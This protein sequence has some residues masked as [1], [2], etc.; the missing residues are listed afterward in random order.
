MWPSYLK[1]AFDATDGKKVTYNYREYTQEGA[2]VFLEKVAA[3]ECRE[4]YAAEDADG[5]EEALE[6]CFAWKTTTRR[7]TDEPW[8]HDMF[9]KLW[10]RLRKVYDRDRLSPVLT[11][12]ASKRYS[13]RMSKFFEIQRKNLSSGDASKKFVRLFNT[14]SCRENFDVHDLYPGRPDEEVSGE[15]AEQFMPSAR[16]LMAWLSNRTH[17]Q[18]ATR[19][20]EF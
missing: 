3:L 19:L 17:S 16:S 20:R 6:E 4:V 15:L 13:K 8:V 5:K 10:K 18:V 2:N 11:K 12:K 9:T 7:Q 14:Y 1:A